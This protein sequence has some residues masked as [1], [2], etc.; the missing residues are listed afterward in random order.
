MTI[1]INP[2]AA[3]AHQGCVAQPVTH[4]AFDFSLCFLAKLY[5]GVVWIIKST[6]SSSKICSSGRETTEQLTGG[7][8]HK[9]KRK[10]STKGSRKGKAKPAK[11]TRRKQKHHKNH[12]SLS[13]KLTGRGSPGFSWLVF[14]PWLDQATP[15]TWSHK[16]KALKHLGHAALEVCSCREWLMQAGTSIGSHHYRCSLHLWVLRRTWTPGITQF[17]SVAG[18]GLSRWQVARTEQVTLTTTVIN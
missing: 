17:V 9:E 1:S 15:T 14:I 4:V 18:W 7:K 12:Y 10:K 13:T 5:C 3:F 11:S 8:K 6:N 2:L 16:P